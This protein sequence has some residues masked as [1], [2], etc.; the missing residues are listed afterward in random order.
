MTRILPNVPGQPPIIDP[1]LQNVV[2]K[3][4]N[5]AGEIT[6]P[7][8]NPEANADPIHSE[9]RARSMKSELGL[10]SMMQKSELNKQVQRLGIGSR[11]GHVQE[12]QNK[13]NEWRVSHDL[14]PIHSDGIYGKETEAAMKVF[15]ESKG[16]NPDGIAGP[17]VNASLDEMVGRTI[18]Q[19]S[20]TL[21]TVKKE[22]TKIVD[23]TVQTAKKELTNVADQAARTLEKV[24]T[25]ANDATTG[26][27]DTTTKAAAGAAKKIGETISDLF[28]SESE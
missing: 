27:V 9:S 5:V 14:S 15:Q 12:L 13:L 23:Q 21:R 26:V 1:E 18:G 20:E 3:Q 16:F 10:S 22:V 6:K 8:E 17:K 28:S 25:T 19:K 2:P 24:V 11:G 4:E 7:I